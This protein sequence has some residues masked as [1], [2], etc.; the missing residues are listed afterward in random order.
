MLSKYHTT[1]FNLKLTVL[2]KSDPAIGSVMKASFPLA[3]DEIIGHIEVSYLNDLDLY[4]CQQFKFSSIT[5][6]A[7]WLNQVDCNG[8][9]CRV[10]GTG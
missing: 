3:F 5:I 6:F 8:S 10:H 4:Q 1:F 9:I 7:M 2:Q